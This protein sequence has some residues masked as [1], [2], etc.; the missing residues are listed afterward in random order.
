M[1]EMHSLFFFS[2]VRNSFTLDGH[3]DGVFT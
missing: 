3:A 2:R 1:P